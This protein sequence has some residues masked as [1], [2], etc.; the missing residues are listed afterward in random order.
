[1]SSP[2]FIM[3]ET[4]RCAFVSVE[5]RRLGHLSGMVHPVGFDW[6]SMLVRLVVGRPWFPLNLALEYWSN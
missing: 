6:P 5:S 4:Y 2:N 3:K 1:M